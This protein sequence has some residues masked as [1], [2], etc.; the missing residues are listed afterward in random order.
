M[1]RITYVL[2]LATLIAGSDTA[3]GSADL[4]GVLKTTGK[5]VAGGMVGTAGAIAFEWLSPKVTLAGISAVGLGATLMAM[6]LITGVD[7]NITGHKAGLPII[8]SEMPEANWFNLLGMAVAATGYGL[9]HHG[10]KLTDL[11]AEL[12]QT[13]NA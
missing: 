12:A 3:A 5:I 1:K 10:H 7:I 6:R 8:S 4:T 11:L 13:L 2:C 9:Y